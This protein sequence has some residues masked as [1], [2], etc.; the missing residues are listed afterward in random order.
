[1]NKQTPMSLL[2]MMQPSVGKNDMHKSFDN[3]GKSLTVNV[4]KRQGKIF[5]T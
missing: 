4:D 2:N 1:M 3:Q 5:T